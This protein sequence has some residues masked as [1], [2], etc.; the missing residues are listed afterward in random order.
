MGTGTAF[1]VGYALLQGFTREGIDNAAHVGGLVAGALLAWWLPSRLDEA[2][3]ARALRWR[4]PTAALAIAGVVAAGIAFA[5]R[6]GID[7]RAQQEVTARAD[8]ALKHFGEVLRLIAAD[9]QAQKDGRRTAREVD[10]RSRD[11][12]APKM[13][14]VADEL[15]AL[16]PG[17][18]E[19]RTRMVR[20][21][22]RLARVGAEMFAMD[23]NW[24]EGSDEPQ[25]VD[26]V[27]W[28]AL[29]TEFKQ[30]GEQ[31]RVAAEAA[32]KR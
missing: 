20:L 16:P 22:A 4:A 14:A 6:D 5:P 11:V 23:S 12:W 17:L 24:V 9:Q 27:R 25:P 13:R 8:V 2:A 10:D 30:L 18:D 31:I 1:F 28:A 19:N 29:E 15:S 26:P 3:H 21:A 32:R 7:I